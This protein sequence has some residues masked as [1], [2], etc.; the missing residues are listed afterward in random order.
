[1][2][3]TTRITS[4]SYTPQSLKAFF[5]PM[6]IFEL[7]GAYISKTFVPYEIVD[8]LYIIYGVCMPFIFAT[9]FS[10]IKYRFQ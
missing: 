8:L 6:Y 4:V 2:N 5:Y 3:F 7:N 1:M 10:N 9:H